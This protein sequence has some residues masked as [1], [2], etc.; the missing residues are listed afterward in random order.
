M[1]RW[2]GSTPATQM[3]L[4]DTHLK[5]VCDLVTT[6]R[7][8]PGCDE[9]LQGVLQHVARLKDVYPPRTLAALV[10]AAAQAADKAPDQRP[11]RKIVT[12]ALEAA[13]AVPLRAAGDHSLREMR[14]AC[15]CSDCVPV[16]RWAESPGGEPLVLAMA[17][18]RRDHVQAML[19]D[20]GAPLSAET[21]KQGSPHKLKLTK[22]GDLRGQDE[23][24]R[25]RWL[26]H[27]EQLRRSG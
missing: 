25:G 7:C 16:A 21:L 5:A 18:A 8:V 27:L 4:Q 6:I 26:Q 17:Q 1:K 22:P 15:A 10:S 24:Q 9:L 2:R 13:L 23:V 12:H 14:W 20:A 19:Q 11:L 3:A